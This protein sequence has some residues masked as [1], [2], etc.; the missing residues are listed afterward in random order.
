MTN[1]QKSEPIQSPGEAAESIDRKY[2]RLHTKLRTF[3][4]AINRAAKRK[5]DYLADEEQRLAEFAQRY[6]HLPRPPLNPEP[7]PLDWSLFEDGLKDI[8]DFVDLNFPGRAVKKNGAKSSGGAS[9]G[10]CAD[11]RVDLCGPGVSLGNEVQEI[12]G[13]VN[14]GVAPLTIPIHL[15]IEIE[16]KSCQ[17][18]ND[19]LQV[20]DAAVQGLNGVSVGNVHPDGLP[21]AL[22]LTVTVSSATPHSKSEVDA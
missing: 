3:A 11:S 16:G 1:I 13:L 2:D 21:V 9:E 22:L 15:N 10:F 19:S 8:N 14:R 12:Q 7:A 6:P 5:S 17:G 20:N 18:D 4:S